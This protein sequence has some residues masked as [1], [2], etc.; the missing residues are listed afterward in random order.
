MPCYRDWEHEY[1]DDGNQGNG[2]Y[3]YE[4]T[5]YSDH[6]KPDQ[7]PP[8]P[9]EYKTG[10]EEYEDREIGTSEDEGYRLEQLGD[11]GDET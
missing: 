7:N 1:E 4:H 11:E 6:N 10:Y 2:E 8:D 9:Y 3:E 5:S